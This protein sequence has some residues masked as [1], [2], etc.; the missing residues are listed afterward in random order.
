MSDQFIRMQYSDD[1]GYNF[2]NWEEVPIGEVGEY[3]Q[4]VYFTQLGSSTQRIYRFS[5]SSPR[6]R[7]ILGATV[8]LKGTIG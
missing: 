5:S 1:G 2:S 8:S 6:K 4:K 3:A 7:D